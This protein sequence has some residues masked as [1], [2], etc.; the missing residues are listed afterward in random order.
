MSDA[1][2]TASKRK[3]NPVAAETA[4]DA[5][6]KAA[7]A[8]DKTPFDMYFEKM[9]AVIERT[10]CLGSMVV[11]GLSGDSDDEGSFQLLLI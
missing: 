11:R 1:K 2:N 6:K 10:G 3:D 8:V 7:V 9:N 4:T 5:S